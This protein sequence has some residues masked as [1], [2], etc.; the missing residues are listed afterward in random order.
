MN[1]SPRSV[2]DL[3]LQNEAL[4]EDNDTLY[5]TNEQLILEIRELKDQLDQQQ[6]NVELNNSE[7][8]KIDGEYYSL[9]ELRA[10]ITNCDKL[11]RKTERQN[12]FIK[13]LKINN[14]QLSVERN[15]LQNELDH[16][17]SMSMFEFGNKYASDESLEADGRAFAKS[18][19]GKP[20]TKT[21][22]EEETFIAEGEAEYERTWNIADG[23]DF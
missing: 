2:K 7:L 5:K 19:L 11:A 9:E 15:Q 18:L 22:I 14:S 3:I 1:E 17:K 13:A 23:D 21:D 16:I 4:A 6:H 8:Y 10:F 12:R 20:M